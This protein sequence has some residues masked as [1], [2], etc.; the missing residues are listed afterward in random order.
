MKNFLKL[1]LIALFSALMVNCS[2]AS[3]SG[4]VFDASTGDAVTSYTMVITVGDK[5]FD[6]SS[7]QAQDITVNDD[8]TYKLSDGAVEA[9]RGMDFVMEISAAG[10]VTTKVL[11]Q[12]GYVSGDANVIDR[13]VLNVRLYPA[14]ATDVVINVQANGTNLEGARVVLSPNAETN[15]FSAAIVQDPETGTT[16]DGDALDPKAALTDASGN[17]T[18]TAD[19]LANNY[20]YAYSATA[21]GYVYVS[22]TATTITVPESSDIT[23]YKLFFDA[24][25]PYL[26]LALRDQSNVDLITGLPVAGTTV[27]FTFTHNVKVNEDGNK[28]LSLDT[29]T[30]LSF[31]A[32]QSDLDQDGVGAL[33]AAANLAT[34]PAAFAT[35]YTLTT[36]GNTVT[37]AFDTTAMYTGTLDADDYYRFTAATLYSNVDVYKDGVDVNAGG[38]SAPGSNYGTSRLNLGGNAWTNLVVIQYGTG[39]PACSAT[40]TVNCNPTVK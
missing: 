35:G 15:N 29:L 26:N 6:S 38:G 20:E 5:T 22:R 37:V 8:G 9:M 31:L 33:T 32:I 17:A 1:S 10:Y 2:S 14:S 40:I 30:D 34:I 12:N 24:E 19:T 7:T 18:F 4:L 36:F 27:V 13:N 28:G 16:T 21:A 11:G 23:T 25:N 39:Y 3:V